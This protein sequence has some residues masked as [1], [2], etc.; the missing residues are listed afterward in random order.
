M[1]EDLS[2]EKKDLLFDVVYNNMLQMINLPLQV[3]IRSNIDKDNFSKLKPFINFLKTKGILSKKNVLFIPGLVDP[4][5]SKSEWSKKFVSQTLK[6]R[7]QLLKEVWVDLVEVIDDPKFLLQAHKSE[8]GLCDAKVADTFIIGPDGSLYNYYSFVGYDEGKIG[9]I[10][11]GLNSNYVE[12]LFSG[13]KKVERCLE[14]KCPFVPLCT[15][16]CFYKAYV[17]TGNPFER[18]CP[19]DFY[20]NIWLPIKMSIYERI[21]GREKVTPP[22]NCI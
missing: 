10:R 15:G 6:D 16:G 19:K 14:E 21:L 20:E 2:R 7:V 8:F 13:D 18:A 9:D 4:S 3:M 17:E 12:F 11:N 22:K 5:P 1:R